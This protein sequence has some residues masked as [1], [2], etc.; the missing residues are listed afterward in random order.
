MANLQAFRE[1]VHY[2]A[3]TEPLAT[4]TRNKLQF[5]PKVLIV[6]KRTCSATA[7]DCICT[8]YRHL[9][10]KKTVLPSLLPLPEDVGQ[11]T[12]LNEEQHQKPTDRLEEVWVWSGNMKQRQKG[13]CQG[14]IE[15]VIN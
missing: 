8:E 5:P 12:D 14:M 4:F 1:K 2:A 10:L 9:Q 15:N 7:V 3:S 6:L 13:N 11:A